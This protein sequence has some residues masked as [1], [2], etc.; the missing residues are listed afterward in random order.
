MI[1]KMDK[2]TIDIFE[3]LN[4]PG[5]RPS[6][7]EE[8]VGLAYLATG[9]LL[10]FHGGPIAF[11][12]LCLMMMGCLNWGGSVLLSRYAREKSRLPKV[13]DHVE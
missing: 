1:D 3:S 5:L 2:K 4:V 11:L 8:L 10:W 9:G 12:G 7:R 13:K 6:D